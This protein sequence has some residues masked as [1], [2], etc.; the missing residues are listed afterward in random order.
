VSAAKVEGI[1]GDLERAIKA[2][3]PEIRQLFLAAK[4][5]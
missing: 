4:G 3:Y 2:R 5:D 1:V